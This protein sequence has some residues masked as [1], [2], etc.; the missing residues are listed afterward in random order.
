MGFPL[1]SDIANFHHF[2]DI[3][4]VSIVW[5]LVRVPYCSSVTLPMPYP[6][7]AAK[8]WK[9]SQQHKTLMYRYD[10]RLEKAD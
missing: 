5:D 10:T 7:P 3:A 1:Q 2:P 4:V 6:P 8:L 9:C